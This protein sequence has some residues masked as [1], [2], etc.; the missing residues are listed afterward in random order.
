VN[1][2]EQ[3]A[4]LEALLALV[5]SRSRAQSLP[6]ATNGATLEAALA[7]APLPRLEPSP[8]PPRPPPPPQ[9][10]LEVPTPLAAFRPSPVPPAP[11]P[12]VAPEARLSSAPK[13]SQRPEAPA[14]FLTPL[15][16]AAQ[17][18]LVP[19]APPVPFA[20]PESSQV[21]P[22]EP[23]PMEVVEL[24][25]DPDPSIPP[26]SLAPTSGAE[27]LESR[28]R[29]VSAPPL[30]LEQ[31]EEDGPPGGYDSAASDPTIEIAA[32][33]VSRLELEAIEADEVSERAPTSS[34]RP[35]SLEEKM[36]E[37][38]DAPL[39]TPPRE[40]GALPAASPAIDVGF[41]P[42]PAPPAMA[43][44]RAIQVAP[45]QV[46]VAAFVGHAPDAPASSFGDLLDATLAL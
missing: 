2:E 13:V 23:P 36:S 34:R 16:T 40:S 1:V 20:P 33:E 28:S 15:R 27:V 41:E 24:D 32:A 9:S 45:T 7:P 18:P 14:F 25:V 5:R 29:L 22:H 44:P 35:I 6:S 37:P 43:A 42:A 39:H 30:A 46:E 38:D 17:K 10:P 3:I 19:P 12:S 21:R 11:S 8:A 26:P 31:D 4:K